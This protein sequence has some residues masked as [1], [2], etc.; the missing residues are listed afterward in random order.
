[1]AVLEP[2]TTG[3][4]LDRI[5]TLYRRNFLLFFVIA[6]VPQLGMML[7]STWP[8]VM[9]ATA[10]EGLPRGGSVAGM[11]AVGVVACLL[12]FTLLPL[13]QGATTVAVSDVYLGRPAS[14]GSSYR[15]TFPL[16]LRLLGLM[17]GLGL[18]VGFGFLLLIVPGI[19]FAVTYALAITVMAIEKVSFSE[20]MTRSKDLVKGNRG[21]V[22]L[23]FLLTLVISYAVIFSFALPVALLTRFLGKNSPML[24]IIL[25]QLTSALARA[26]AMPIGLIGYTLAYYNARVKKEAFD[27]QYMMELDAAAAGGATTTTA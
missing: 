9:R 18:L 25:N 6:L 3:Q 14:V 8:M 4:L 7:M 26:L 16:T 11:I 23:I 2:L 22:A 21:R 12:Y 5:F 27:L 15:A 10:H 17:I 1:M 13:S 20:A 19:Y 24:A